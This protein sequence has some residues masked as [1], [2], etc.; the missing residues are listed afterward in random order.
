MPKA[1]KQ[2]MRSGQ[3][4]KNVKAASAAITQWIKL[5][6][7][8]TRASASEPADSGSISNRLKPITLKMVFTASL[9]DV[10]H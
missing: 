8:S 5:R 9:L 7:S 6:W 4:S 3:G 2:K 1:N 10:Q